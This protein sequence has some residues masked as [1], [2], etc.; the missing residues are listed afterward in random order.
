MDWSSRGYMSFEA[1]LPSTSTM[2]TFFVR[3]SGTVSTNLGVCGTRYLSQGI[4]ISTDILNDSV[5]VNV[6][7]PLIDFY[8][9]DYVNIQDIMSIECVNTDV[10]SGDTL[11]LVRNIQWFSN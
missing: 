1:L 8:K 9:K 10:A 3:M 11:M 5:F 7:L 6:Q 4:N 2:S